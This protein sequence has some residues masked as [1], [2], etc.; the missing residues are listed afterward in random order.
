MDILQQIIEIDKAA[1]ARVEA[2]RE[3]QS[4]KLEESAKAAAQLSEQRI[5]AARSELESFRA[6]QQAA[7]DRKKGGAEAQGL[8]VLPVAEAAKAAEISRI[9]DI[10]AAHREEWQAKVLKKVT[11]I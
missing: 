5:S 6:E 2:L 4:T 10:F 1:A 8:K 7:L 9:D 11:G 3:E